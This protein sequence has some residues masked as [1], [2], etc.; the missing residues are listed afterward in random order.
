MIEQAVDGGGGG[1]GLGGGSG[2]NQLRWIELSCIFFF[3]CDQK[4]ADG[5]ATTTGAYLLV[6]LRPG[7]RVLDHS[8]NGQD[9]WL[10]L[11]PLA[12][13]RG[14]G[15]TVGVVVITIIIVIIIRTQQH[16]WWKPCWPSAGLWKFQ[17]VF[18]YKGSVGAIRKASSAAGSSDEFAAELNY[19]QLK[20]PFGWGAKCLQDRKNKS[21]WPQT[22][23]FTSL[24]IDMSMKVPSHLEIEG[25]ATGL[26][27]AILRMFLYSF[28]GLLQ[29]LIVQKRTTKSWRSR[30]DERRKVFEIE[31]KSSWPNLTLLFHW[32][33]NSVWLAVRNVSINIFTFFNVFQ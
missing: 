19:Q 29:L 15:D 3:Y 20:E 23:P 8:V 18:K 4:P 30:S 11:L 5:A 17:V 26:A 31:N 1:G 21:S 27:L 33:L 24:T 12:E 9:D 28:K 16:L 13:H 22:N 6:E 14:G 7:R 10:V 2:L 32:P 25:P